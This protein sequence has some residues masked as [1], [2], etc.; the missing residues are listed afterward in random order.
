MKKEG[1]GKKTDMEEMDD[2]EEGVYIDEEE[3]GY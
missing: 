3:E 1:Y 2:M